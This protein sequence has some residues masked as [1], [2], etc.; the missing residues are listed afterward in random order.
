MDFTLKEA[1]APVL[2]LWAL[3]YNVT[4]RGSQ[5]VAT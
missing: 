5:L 3:R 4:S 2:V 1:V